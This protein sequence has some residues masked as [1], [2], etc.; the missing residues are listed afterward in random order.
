LVELLE[1]AFGIYVLIAD[2]LVDQ[3]ED[4]AELFD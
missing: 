3:Q 2:E 4:L 1:D